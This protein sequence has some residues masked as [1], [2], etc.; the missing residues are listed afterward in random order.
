MT[1]KKQAAQQLRERVCFLTFTGDSDA[2]DSCLL[3]VRNQKR[4]GGR[5]GGE[6]IIISWAKQ[7][8]VSAQSR[9]KHFTE[10]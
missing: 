1:G 6:L 9:I 5:E 3:G 10:K 4:V 8:P 7:L 2:V